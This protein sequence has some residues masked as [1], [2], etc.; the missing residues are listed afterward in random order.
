MKNDEL[1]NN[2]FSVATSIAYTKKEVAKLKESIDELKSIDSTPKIIQEYYVGE[3]GPKGDTGPQGLQGLIGEQGIPGQKGERGEQGIPGPVGPAGPQ[4]IRG[5][6]GDQGIAGQKGEKGD[7]GIQGPIGPIGQKGDRGE[8]GENG[9][10]GIPGERG[11]KGEPGEIGP[12]GIRG[13]Q[14]IPGKDGINGKDGLPGPK[15][16]K[17]DPGKDGDTTLL[18]TKFTKFQDGIQ[19][20]L[21][22]Y[23]N[24]INTVISKGFGGETSGSG[25]Y[26]LNDL[27]DTDKS[28][29]KSATDGQVLAYS[30]S[31]KKWIASDAGSGT[32]DSY[33]RSLAQSAYD[34]ANSAGS[35]AQSAYDYAN[36]ITVNT[37][38]QYARDKANSASSN[39]IYTQG[40][41]NTQNTNITVARNLAQAAFDYANTLVF[42]S[43]DQFARDT[44]NSASSNTIQL[45]HVDI[46]QNN[47]INYI[48]GGLNSANA[49]ITYLF[50]VNAVQNTNITITGNLAQAAFDKAN[51]YVP[52]SNTNVAS[53]L[54]GSITT[55]NIIVNSTVAGDAFTIIA[56]PY[57]PVGKQTWTFATQTGIGSPYTSYMRWPDGTIQY[58][59]FDGTAIDQYARDTAN[60]ASANTIYIQGV[61]DSQNSWISSNNSYFQEVL[62]QTNNNIVTSNTQLKSY[63]DGQLSTKVN[64]SGDTI[65]GQLNVSFSPA[66]TT[67]TA[68]TITAANTKGGTGYADTL[69]MTNASGGA[70]NPNM[71]FRLNSTGGFEIL[72]STYANNITSVSQTGLLGLGKGGGVTNNIPTFN[73]LQ[74]NGR[75]YVYDDGNMHIQSTGGVIWIN[76]NDGSDVQINTQSP[77]TGGLQVGGNLQANSGYGSVATMYG[78]RAWIVCGWNGTSMVTYGSGNLSVSRSSTG[79]YVFTFGSNMPDGNY[80]VTATAQ[81]PNGNSDVAANI[82]N[83]TSTLNTGFTIATA[84]YGDGFKDVPRL[85]IQVVR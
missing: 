70:T 51:T 57:T 83:G 71:Y 16:D 55:G 74:L 82:H 37:I 52:Y 39:T 65:T 84:R 77:A 43:V 45:Q 35:L 46:T 19:K 69:L 8:R 26:W 23:K 60:S 1:L 15:G 24:K 59:A 11:E 4:G 25:S 54:T 20:D 79:I 80:C 33:A 64:K 48:Q 31:I 14:G 9:S 63:T 18:E 3:Q 81:T 10:Q 61:N 66:S 44:A 53:Y 13:E 17:G 85:C 32:V 6:K 41:D 67:G 34:Q 42:S 56:E 40:V 22:N 58:T 29:L 72:N 76:T 47:N 30:A 36:T 27:G 21:A 7:Q 49:N 12:Q 62:N 75:S 28:S 78:V 50:A 73:A 2:A 5:E 68:V 38:D